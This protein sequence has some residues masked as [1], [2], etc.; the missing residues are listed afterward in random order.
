[1]YGNYQYFIMNIKD[2][3]TNGETLNKDIT[4][5]NPEVGENTVDLSALLSDDEI[6]NILLK[7]D[8]TFI[9]SMKAVTNAGEEDVGTPIQNQTFT[10]SN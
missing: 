1:M 3:N 2:V 6:N 4:I 7:E 9:I 5:Q 10:R 8:Y